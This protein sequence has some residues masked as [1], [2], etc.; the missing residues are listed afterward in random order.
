M[1]VRFSANLLFEGEY[2]KFLVKIILGSRG[3]LSRVVVVVVVM[4]R[5]L[6]RLCKSEVLQTQASHTRQLVYQQIVIA[7]LLHPIFIYKLPK[8]SIS[9]N[10]K[11]TNKR[12]SCAKELRTC[13]LC[14]QV[15]QSIM[16]AS[17]RGI[18]V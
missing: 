10:Y 1:V 13:P 2:V 18:V 7:T 14:S 11:I 16:A 3:K 17:A 5:V 9:R 12:L 4:F 6:T 8:K 15:L